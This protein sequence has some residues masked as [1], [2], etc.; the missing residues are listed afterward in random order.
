MPATPTSGM[1]RSRPGSPRVPRVHINTFGLENHDRQWH[2][3]GDFSRLTKKSL[4]DL[5]NSPEINNDASK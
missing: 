5:M 4:V 2:K 3:R 1:P